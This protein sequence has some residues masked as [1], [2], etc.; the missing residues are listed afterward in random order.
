MIKKSKKEGAEAILLD[1]R[2]NPGGLLSSV[3]DVTSLFL[4]DGVVI[5]EIKT[6]K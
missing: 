4:N 6:I 3:I 2:N 1:L 5:K